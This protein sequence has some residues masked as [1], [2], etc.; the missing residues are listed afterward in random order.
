MEK[1]KEKHN[2]EHLFEDTGESQGSK[3]LVLMIQREG[4]PSAGPEP[5]PSSLLRHLRTVE[6]LRRWPDAVPE[7]LGH[8]MTESRPRGRGPREVRSWALSKSPRRST[9]I[10]KSFA[11][12]KG[13]VG[14]DPLS[15]KDG[16]PDFSRPHTTESQG[17]APGL[18]A[19][20]KQT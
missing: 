2:T 11:L 10:S 18:P 6:K 9:G 20:D 8:R 3:K 13:E 14:N 17:P 16:S 7:G 12:Q 19:C 5:A 15:E 4:M 1:S